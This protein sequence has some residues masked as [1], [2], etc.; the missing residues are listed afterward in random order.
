[1]N[2]Q[3]SRNVFTQ[4][5]KKNF[6]PG[7]KYLLGSFC[8]LDQPGMHAVKVTKLNRRDLL[9]ICIVI[10]ECLHCLIA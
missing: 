1:M 9:T 3:N 2:T 8:I 6:N 4:I 10:P 5:K 7:T